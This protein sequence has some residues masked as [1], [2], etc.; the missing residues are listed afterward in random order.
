MS[1]IDDK[2]MMDFAIALDKA[3]LKIGKLESQLAKLQAENRRYRT[4]LR[5]IANSQ[6]EDPLPTGG[7][8]CYYGDNGYTCYAPIAESALGEGKP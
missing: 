5:D 7:C 4:A 2:N 1:E 6:H 8:A 3:N